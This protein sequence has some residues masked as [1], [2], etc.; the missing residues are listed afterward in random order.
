MVNTIKLKNY[1]FIRVL[2]MPMSII[3]RNKH[4]QEVGKLV[5]YIQ[6]HFYQSSLYVSLSVYRMGAHSED[7]LV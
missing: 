6:E 5:P 4:L 1:H 7:I 3:I 2:A